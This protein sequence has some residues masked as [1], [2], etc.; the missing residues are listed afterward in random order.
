MYTQ[1]YIAFLTVSKLLIILVVAHG[2]HLL[3]IYL[4]KYNSYTRNHAAMSTVHA[5]SLYYL[6]Q[7]S[8]A[9]VFTVMGYAGLESGLAKESG[10]RRAQQDC[11]LKYIDFYIGILI[12]HVDFF[13]IKLF[14]HMKY[15][16]K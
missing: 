9:G 2:N 1:R 16:Q 11:V 3:D 10:I 12:K 15:S 6:P 5:N 7:P 14:N 13:A 4:H 8:P